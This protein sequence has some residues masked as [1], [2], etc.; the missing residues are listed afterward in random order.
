MSPDA[1]LSVDA[2]G[3][4]TT[5]LPRWVYIAAH[6]AKSPQSAIL[7]PEALP[8]RGARAIAVG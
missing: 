3:V 6:L 1:S 8:T 5:T 2:V 7:G 4:P